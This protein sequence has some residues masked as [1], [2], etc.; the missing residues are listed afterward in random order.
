MTREI[1]IRETNFQGSLPFAP[2]G[3]SGLS[4][5]FESG[6]ETFER[7]QMLFGRSAEPLDVD[8]NQ[9][10]LYQGKVTRKDASALLVA[11]GKKHSESTLLFEWL[12]WIHE[13][14]REF[15]L[16][17]SKALGAELLEVLH[18]D[19]CTEARPGKRRLLVPVP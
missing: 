13:T 18:A 14:V 11:S 5:A 6:D 19:I 1:A 17:G 3:G 10:P 15:P 16:L 12:A 9:L 8:G 2:V 4:L 7:C